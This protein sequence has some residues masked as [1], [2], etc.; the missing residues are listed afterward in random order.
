[1][2]VS[3]F[4]LDFARSFFFNMSFKTEDSAPHSHIPSAQFCF[5]KLSFFF[6]YTFFSP[7]GT[8][9]MVSQTNRNHEITSKQPPECHG[10]FAIPMDLP[11]QD[12]TV[13]VFAFTIG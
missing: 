9:T 1:M 6:R 13:C 11:F 3:H 8:R 4:L 5:S 7:A 2:F 12:V 10:T